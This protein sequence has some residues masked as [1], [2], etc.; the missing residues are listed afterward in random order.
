MRTVILALA[1]AFT[2]LL[3]SLTVFVVVTSGRIG[4]LEVISVLVLGMFA[5]GIIGALTHPP[6]DR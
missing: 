2:A 3:G 5:F 1:L 6:D 4:V